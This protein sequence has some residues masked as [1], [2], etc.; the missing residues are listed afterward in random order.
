[1]FGFDEAYPFGELDARLPELLANQEA[2]HT[3]VGA[4]PAWD[5][6]VAGWLNAVRAKVRTGVTAP[7]ADPRRARRR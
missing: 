4:D 5:A 1:M 3:P 7:G 6:R 2:L